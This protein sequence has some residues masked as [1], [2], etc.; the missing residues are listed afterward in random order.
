MKSDVHNS[1]AAVFFLSYNLNPVR[2]F[3]NNIICINQYDARPYL[4]LPLSALGVSLRVSPSM[5]RIRVRLS[6]RY[7][8]APRSH[9][10]NCTY[11]CQTCICDKCD[12]YVNI[13]NKLWHTTLQLWNDTV[14]IAWT[15]R[16][17]L[18]WCNLT[19]SNSEDDKE[20]HTPQ[21]SLQTEALP[22]S[23]T[24]L[25]KLLKR[26][27]ETPPTKSWNQVTTW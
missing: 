22:L 6:D 1:Y 20:W 18:S 8:H 2:S 17:D 19:S 16:W 27:G 26:S 13:N 9:W 11:M 10:T 15:H 23:L 24:K 5:F 21:E 25:T 7:V 12:C 14:L 3:N 4:Y